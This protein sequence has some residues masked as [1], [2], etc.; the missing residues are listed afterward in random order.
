FSHPSVHRPGQGTCCVAEVVRLRADPPEVSR[1]RL[2]PTRFP[3]PLHF[4]SW[5]VHGR[6]AS[7]PRMRDVVPQ[8]DDRFLTALLLERQYA[9]TGGAPQQ[10]PRGGRGRRAPAGRNQ[11]DDVGTGER[12]DGALDATYPGDE[13]VGP[14]GDVLRRFTIGA[15]VAEHFPAGP[16][17]QNV[18]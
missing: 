1:L 7:L 3:C 4:F 13:V 15:A 10:N 2:P 12:Q 5:Y 11:P 18:L 9:H 8:A 14:G 16:L 6:L 17:L